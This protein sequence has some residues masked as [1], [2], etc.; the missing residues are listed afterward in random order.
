MELP[1][2]ASKQVFDKIIMTIVGNVRSGISIKKNP[3]N[4]VHF[5]NVVIVV[6]VVD[7]SPSA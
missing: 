7:V 2:E 6:I 1:L 4:A 5:A 3:A